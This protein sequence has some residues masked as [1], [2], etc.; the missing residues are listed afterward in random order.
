MWDGFEEVGR[1]TSEMMARMDRVRLEAAGIEATV[2]TDNCG[3]MGP[4]FDLQ[5]GVRLCVRTADAEAARDLLR[6]PAIPAS[7]GACPVCGTAGEPGFAA[8]WRCGHESV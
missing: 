4:Q 3:G 2:E 1:Y 5:L 7:P 6:T 8:C